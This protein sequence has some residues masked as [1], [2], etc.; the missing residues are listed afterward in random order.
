MLRALFIFVLITGHH[1]KAASSFQEDDH[2]AHESTPAELQQLMA[3]DE[4]TLPSEGNVLHSGEDADARH[5]Q[6]SAVPCPGGGPINYFSLKIDFIPQVSVDSSKCTLALRQK[7]GTDLN[8]LLLSYGIGP[9]GVG[10]GAAYI[11]TV[12]LSPTS[13]YKARRLATII[14]FTWKGGGTCKSCPVDNGD[15]RRLVRRLQTSDPNWFKNIYVPE[16]QNIL[17]NA[18]TSTVV[19][20]H[21]ICL[22]GGPQV[23]VVVQEILSTQ[24]K[25]TC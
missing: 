19:P 5:L 18:I 6:L 12:C 15:G 25:T 13:S 23:L 20:K 9:N 22:G 7:I 14:G 11:A 21:P 16:L 2:R 1:L 3:L 4:L 17:R 24:L 8:A 10:D